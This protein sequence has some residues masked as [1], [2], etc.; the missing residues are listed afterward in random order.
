MNTDRLQELIE[1]KLTDVKK[2]LEADETNAM[3]MVDFLGCVSLPP[4]KH[5][6][7]AITCVRVCVSVCLCVSVSVSVSV[8][9]YGYSQVRHFHDC[10]LKFQRKV[11]EAMQEGLVATAGQAVAT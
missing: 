8:C 11:V 1:Q 10:S 7:S 3:V 2:Q 6:T 9:L 5:C 4:C